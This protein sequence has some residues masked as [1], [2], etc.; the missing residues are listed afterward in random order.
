MFPISNM[1]MNEIQF[2]VTSIYSSVLTCRWYGL[3]SF[4][5]ILYTHVCHNS[6]SA[7]EKE[8]N[9][10]NY[11]L[12]KFLLFAFR[13]FD[14]I[15][16]LL[17]RFVPAVGTIESKLIGECANKIQSR[18]ADHFPFEHTHIYIYLYAS[19]Q[20]EFWYVHLRNV[21]IARLREPL[22]ACTREKSA[23]DRELMRH[24]I[25]KF[26]YAAKAKANNRFGIF[27][28]SS[29]T[30]WTFSIHTNIAVRPY[31]HSFFIWNS[32]ETDFCHGI[33]RTRCGF[34]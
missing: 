30:F 8:M 32:T 19:N 10:K 16:K 34:N 17:R 21:S 27:I 29:S 22:Q 28:E 6:F 33:L 1:I 23:S 15:R 24:V 11:Y 20:L 31:S 7:K 12:F 4:S 9:E 13:T 26:V 2:Q 5:Y 3:I 14:M 18:L 25:I